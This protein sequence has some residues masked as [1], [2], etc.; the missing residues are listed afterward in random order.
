[1]NKKAS[2]TAAGTFPMKLVGSG[3]N[4]NGKIRPFHV[5]LN[6]TNL[7]NLNCSFCSCSNRD[8]ALS[9]DFDK[10]KDIMGKF[11]AMGCRAVTI[12][13]GGEP[14]LYKEI[15]DVIH[16]L[17][18]RGVRSGL[19]TNGTKLENLKT[20]EL[21]WVRVS[22]SDS[23]E[24]DSDALRAAVK[25][26]PDIDWSLSYVLSEKPN[27]QNIMKTVEL[28]NIFNFTHVRIVSDLLNLKNVSM[29]EVMKHIEASQINDNKIIYQER[30]EFTPGRKDC[31]I[32][33]L[34]PVVGADG[35]IYPCCGV[36]YAEREPSLDYNEGMCMGD[37]IKAIWSQ[38]NPFDGSKCV[39]C[40]YSA[41]NHLLS[42]MKSLS[43]VDFV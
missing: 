20:E 6:P 24:F 32:S 9:I 21:T 15:N 3:F 41:Y 23:R 4:R 43:H 10:L 7:C 17:Y 38:Q 31:W 1:M 12:T 13:G 35:K 28:A 39:K 16:F 14:L 18:S 37:D 22:A 27:I 30:K 8:K 2:Y 42:E 29:I 36:Q 19:V 26:M 33:L 25:R 40:Y 11:I 34:K 5:Q